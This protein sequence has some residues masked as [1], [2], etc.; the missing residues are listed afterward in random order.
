MLSPTDAASQEPVVGSRVVVACARAP[1]DAAV[2]HCFKYLGS[3][4]PELELEG[5]A[6]SVVQID[7]VLPEATCNPTPQS[8]FSRSHILWGV[9]MRSYFSLNSLIYPV[10]SLLDRKVYDDVTTVRRRRH[11]SPLFIPSTLSCV[12]GPASRHDTYVTH[13]PVYFIFT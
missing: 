2:Q 8:I 4:H 1:R 11:H 10:R 5:S 7:G 13:Y 12:L 3:S 9:G 6:R